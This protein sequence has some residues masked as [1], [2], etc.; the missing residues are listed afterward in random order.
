MK[1][2]ARCIS[3]H[4][5][6]WHKFFLIM[7]LTTFFILATVLQVSAKGYSQEKVTVNFENV[8]L[9]KALKEVERKSS[10]HFVYSN[11]ILTDKNK[12]TL[13]AT[14]IKVAELLERLL[15]NTGLTFSV[16]GNHLVVIKKEGETIRDV[17][18]K[19]KVTDQSNGQPL[20]GESR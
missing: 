2:T 3:L 5:K 7:R 4:F 6:C 14:D 8:R 19:G 1:K 15:K 17:H 11:L 9:D 18:V 12:V 10:F 20:A 16:M 13:Q